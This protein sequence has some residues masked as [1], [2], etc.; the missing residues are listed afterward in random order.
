MWKNVLKVYEEGSCDR[1]A[2]KKTK[3]L[4]SKGKEDFIII[5]GF[6]WTVMGIEDE[7]PTEH[8]WI[9]F[10][11]GTLFDPSIDQFDKYGGIEERISEGTPYDEE[12]G[13]YYDKPVK[14][15][16]PKEYLKMC[17]EE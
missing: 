1:V 9:Q 16:S 11:D 13:E 6:V 8:T 2:I 3:E 10:N 15:Y 17:K 12:T 14:H 5:E 4:L 7:Y